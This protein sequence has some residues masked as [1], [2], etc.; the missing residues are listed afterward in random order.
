MALAP[1]PAR[2]FSDAAAFG[3]AI[4]DALTSLNVPVGASDLAALLSIVPRPAPFALDHA[5]DVEGDPPR[6][7]SAGP[8][9][10]HRG[11]DH[12]RA[13]GDVWD[14]SGAPR[15]HGSGPWWARR[16]RGDAAS[17]N[18]AAER[19]PGSE[20]RPRRERRCPREIPGW[21][22]PPPP[23]ANRPVDF[24]RPPSHERGGEPRTRLP[25]T[26]SAHP[27]AGHSP[28]PVAPPDRQRPRPATA[29]ATD[30][31]R[32]LCHR[33]APPVGSRRP[34]DRPSGFVIPAGPVSPDPDRA[35][36]PPARRGWRTLLCCCCCSERLP[37]ASTSSWCLSTSCW[38]GAS[39]PDSSSPRTERRHA[40]ARWQAARRNLTRRIEVPRV[41]GHAR[42][43]RKERLSCGAAGG[44][45]Q[46]RRPPAVPLALDRPPGPAAAARPEGRGA[47]TGV[48]HPSTCSRSTSLGT[49][50]GFRASRG[51]ARS[52]LSYPARSDLG[53]PRTGSEPPAGLARPRDCHR[54]TRPRR[55]RH[56]RQAPGLPVRARNRPL[57]PNGGPRVHV[58]AREGPLL[59]AASGDRHEGRRRRRGARRLDA[60]RRSSRPLKY[61]S[62]RPQTGAVCWPALGATRRTG[63][64]AA[65]GGL[66]EGC[67]THSGGG[68][69]AAVPAAAAPGGR[70]GPAQRPS[71]WSGRPRRDAAAAA[72]TILRPIP[73]IRTS[74]STVRNG[75]VSGS[76][77]SPPPWTARRPGSK[78]S[79]SGGRRVEVHDPVDRLA[80]PRA[81]RSDDQRQREDHDGERAAA[82]PGCRCRRPT[83][84]GRQRGGRW[85]A[86]GRQFVGTAGRRTSVVA[87]TPDGQDL[88]PLAS[89]LPALVTMTTVS[90]VRQT[91]TQN[92]RS[93][94]R[95]AHSPDDRQ[96]SFGGAVVPQS[97]RRGAATGVRCPAIRVRSRVPR[98]VGASVFAVGIAGLGEILGREVPDAGGLARAGRLV[99]ALDG[100]VT[101]GCDRSQARAPLGS[102]SDAVLHSSP[103]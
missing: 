96:T 93:V 73:L 40:A 18:A 42:R 9:R 36:R 71:P 24:R 41:A 16:C 29:G 103:I 49:L 89:R 80:R 44:P 82:R 11:A 88:A 63:C 57:R 98:R 70:S 72:R 43:R 75:A 38:P 32:R 20:Q 1:D 6:R 77:R 45:I 101:T 19:R 85:R 76:P 92:R 67:K 31:P 27:F 79:I 26:A 61:S 39:R 83:G 62:A 23:R 64:G 3:A 22:R 86:R 7:R 50:G 30:G 28:V 59:R 8:A 66:Q 52:K 99:T 46:S 25:R 65:T 102:Q 12:A 5:G 100:A 58:A 94:E 13:R 4:R 10:S 69:G 81:A 95:G 21:D 60:P 35:V 56:R 33:H 47:S 15:W 87:P 90:V 51:L 54:P 17:W 74:S 91:F 48:R 34:P 2:R 14:H 78:P 84:C 68:G 37:P 97:G 55:A 53:T